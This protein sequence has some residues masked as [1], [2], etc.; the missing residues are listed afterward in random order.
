M[1]KT[2]VKTGKDI[3]LFAN[4]RNSLKGQLYFA[5]TCFLNAIKSDLISE[6][7]K[8]ALRLMVTN[9]TL[10]LSTWDKHYT[11]ELFKQDDQ[12]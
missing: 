2:H 11:K 12:A 6:E 7:N 10:I 4:R 8:I 3:R 1:L 5:K 9:L